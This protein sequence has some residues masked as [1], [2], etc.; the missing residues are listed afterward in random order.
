MAFTSI[1]VWAKNAATSVKSFTAALFGAKSATSA[2]GASAGGASGG[3]GKLMTL[4]GRLNWCSFCLR[5]SIP[6]I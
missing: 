6:S 1:S 2:F 5:I 4:V 3:I